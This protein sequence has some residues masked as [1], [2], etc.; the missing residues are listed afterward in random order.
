[1]KNPYLQRILE[2]AAIGTVRMAAMLPR[3]AVR[4][5]RI[6]GSVIPSLQHYPVSTRYGTI[7]CDLRETICFDLFVSGEYSRWRPDMEAIRRIP[8]NDRSIVLDVGAN[9]GVLTRLFAERSAHVHAFEPA[10]RA[11]P[12]LRANAPDNA[13]VHPV[14]VGNHEG[15]VRFAENESLDMSCVAQDGIEVPVATI[16]SFALDADFIKIDVEGYEVEVLQGAKKTIARREPLIMFEAL[17]EMALQSCKAEILAISSNYEFEAF[18]SG[19]NFLARPRIPVAE[20]L[21]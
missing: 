5:A 4:A 16:D 19:T 12:L 17:N 20:V 2:K 15:T 7:Y 11:L 10:L 9:I 18:P 6:L 8:L 1:M 13:T 14:A 3:G 21:S